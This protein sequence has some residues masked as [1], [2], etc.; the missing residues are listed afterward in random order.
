MGKKVNPIIFRIGETITWRS[1]WFN[2]KKYQGYLR[3]DYFLRKLLTDKL[4]KQGLSNIEI[5]RS[6]NELKIIIHTSRPGLIIGRGGAGI[7]SLKKEIE[8]FHKTIKIDKTSKTNVK[9]QI[10]EVAKPESNAQILGQQIADQ[11][12]KRIP[13]RRVL[14]Q[15]IEKIMQSNEVQGVKIM[16]SGRLDG[17]EMAR[18]EWLAKGNIPLQTLRAD[19]DYAQS[20]AYCRYGVIGIKIWIYKGEVFN[21]EIK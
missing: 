17:S 11:I 15:F 1:R 9:I 3:E 8:N 6:E 2:L 4:I 7:D 14:K 20:R 18:R 19:I 13:F 16:V 10:D 5:E 21:N 12:E